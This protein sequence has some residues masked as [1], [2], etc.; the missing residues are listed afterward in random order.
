[1]TKGFNTNIPESWRTGRRFFR[2]VTMH[3][4]LLAARKS[5]FQPFRSLPTESP[6][7]VGVRGEVG[8]FR[9]IARQNRPIRP[10]ES[11]FFARSDTVSRSGIRIIEPPGYS[12][13]LPLDFAFEIMRAFRRCRASAASVYTR[14]HPLLLGER[15]RRVE[16]ETA[17]VAEVQFGGGP[18]GINLRPPIL[19][20]RLEVAPP[21]RDRGA[22]V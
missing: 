5:V 8:A 6:G 11:T 22:D 4:R 12:V 13:S 16:D 10:E 9:A 21:D 2:V 3:M 15:I 18:S 1:M 19:S 7:S 17:S 14:D 20:E